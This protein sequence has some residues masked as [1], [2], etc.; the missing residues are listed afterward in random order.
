MKLFKKLTA[1]TINLKQN[2]CL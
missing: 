1:Y 2:S